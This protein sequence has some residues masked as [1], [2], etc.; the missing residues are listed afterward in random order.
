MIDLRAA[1]DHID[2]DMLFSV[3]N[4]RTKARKITSLLKA[5]YNGTKASIK[6]TVNSFHVHTGC[7]LGGIE[8][9]VLF[10]IYMD[11]VLRCVEHDVLLKYPNTGLKYSYKI[12]SESSNREQ[13]SIHK[14]SGNYRLRM[15]LYAD[16]IVLF[17]E[18]IDELNDILNIYDSTFSLF[19][20]TIAIENAD[21]RLC[22]CYI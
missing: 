1:Y 12:K 17:C 15:L 19:G 8:S 9:S 7:R 5:L 4:I 6:N 16:D 3:L 13:R 11:F 18:D 21:T 14:I 10:N 20:L 2:R 22:I